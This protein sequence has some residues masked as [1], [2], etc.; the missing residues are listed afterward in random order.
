MG[1]DTTRD[2]SS[3][4][5]REEWIEKQKLRRKPDDAAYWDKRAANFSNKSGGSA[6]ISRFIEHM[7]I[8]PGESVFDMGCGNG[9]I[10]LPL[11]EE[12][13]EILAADFS[14]GMLD[15]LEREIEQR[16]LT[17]VQVKQFSWQDD[18]TSFGLT[19]N[20]FDLAIA[21]RSIVTDDLGGA[22]IKLNDVARKKVCVTLTNGG[23]VRSNPTIFEAVGRS[24]YTTSDAL[25]CLNI[26]FQRGIQPELRSINSYK[27]DRFATFEDA[28]EHYKRMLEDTSPREEQ[29][30]AAYLKEHL[31]FINAK[32]TGVPTF[33]LDTKNLISWAFISWNPR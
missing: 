10:T 13:H 21:S 15:H 11:A 27:T 5:W 12:G 26:L 6:Y 18:W 31:L 20:S 9:A 32:T 3:I 28:F 8:Q 25:Y 7:D 4:D 1:D 2:I 23:S 22:L 24:H 16:N 19:D 29:L 14:R 30:L 33:E 17:A